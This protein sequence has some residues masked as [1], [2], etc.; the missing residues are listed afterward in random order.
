MYVLDYGDQDGSVRF[1]GAAVLFLSAFDFAGQVFVGGRQ[2][3][4]FDEGAR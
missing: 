2:A 3:A 1:Q 4:E